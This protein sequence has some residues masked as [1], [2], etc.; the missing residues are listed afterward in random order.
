MYLNEQNIYRLAAGFF[1]PKICS[2]CSK[3]GH[4]I[5]FPQISSEPIVEFYPKKRRGFY[6]DGLIAADDYR[7]GP[8]R[9]AIHNM[10]YGRV[11]EIGRI[12]GDQ[13]AA[14]ADKFIDRKAVVVPVPLHQKRLR[15]RGFNQA[16]ILAESFGKAGWELAEALTRK[17]ATAVQIDLDRPKRRQN[18]AGA[19]A[20]APAIVQIHGK[21]V[22]LIDDVATTGATLNSCA[23][24]LKWHGAAKVFGL[25]VARD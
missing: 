12:L 16:K 9:E 7:S 25:V 8:L 19:F 17:R 13:L 5:C 22:V 6:L 18:V 1:F 24:V 15:E 14:S 23:K 21:T 4:Y 3:E 11:K 10:K 20:K 2:R